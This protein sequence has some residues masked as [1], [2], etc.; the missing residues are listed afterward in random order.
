MSIRRCRLTTVTK[1]LGANDRPPPI[2]D[3]ARQ[4]GCPSMASLA[5]RSRLLHSIFYA[6]SRDV[7]WLVFL[8]FRFLLLLVRSME[9]EVVTRRSR[10]EAARFTD[11]DQ[12]VERGSFEGLKRA[13]DQSMFPYFFPPFSLLFRNTDLRADQR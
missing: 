1:K 3:T 8:L 5:S 12:A 9:T 11:D 13:R 10:R 6:L 4:I 2:E 7:S